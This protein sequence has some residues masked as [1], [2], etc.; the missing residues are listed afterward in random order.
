MHRN[1]QAFLTL[2][3]KLASA[4]IHC[5]V[6]TVLVRPYAKVFG[7]RSDVLERAGLT[8]YDRSAEFVQNIAY[9]VLGCKSP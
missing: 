9:S 5:C 6:V 3:P 4:S 2:F 1:G 8:M 7:R